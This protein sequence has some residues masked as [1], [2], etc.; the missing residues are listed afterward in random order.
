MMQ[1][2]QRE[3]ATFRVGERSGRVEES[4]GTVLRVTLPDAQVGEI[5]RVHRVSGEPIDAEVIGFDRRDALLMP[6][7]G[8]DGI[9]A[10]AAVQPTGTVA[11]VVCGAAVEGRV[12]DAV[13]APLDELGPVPAEQYAPLF[14]APPSP[15]RR[16]PLRQALPTG[17]R[18]I[19]AML[20]LAVGQRI[21]LFAGAGVG[22]S[23]LLSQLAR[24]VRADRV[25]IALIGERGRE[26]RGFLED[27]LDAATRARSTIVVSTSDQPALLRLRAAHAATAIA[28]AARARGEHVLLLM[29]SLTRFARAVREVAL[30]AG[31]PPGRQGFPASV[32]ATLPRL[33]ERAGSSAEGAI[34]AIY[35]VLVA[36]DDLEEPVADEAMSLLDGHILLSRRL[37]DRRQFPAIDVARSRS[38]LMNAVVT[39][40]H[41]QDAEVAARVLDLYAANEDRIRAG[42][43]LPDV[44]EKKMLEAHPE[45]LKFL[46]PEGGG[47]GTLPETLAWLRAFAARL[48]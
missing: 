20:T 38:R 15:L 46:Y 48:R 23:T 35:T 12:L 5:C 34:T 24:Q 43:F 33:L 1:E 22:K 31:E 40:E 41:R 39:R 7:G 2:L 37:A 16:Q 18:A 26:V 14:Q 8:M 30:A 25:V 32:F 45:L 4:I 19:D 6:L 27:D 10:G 9:A 44:R 36:G 3:L 17:I 13:G 21:G 29:D 28:E 11:R 42:A 47:P